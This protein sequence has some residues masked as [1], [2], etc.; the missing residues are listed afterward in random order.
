MASNQPPYNQPGQP[1]QPPY[2][3]SGQ[4]S[5]GQDMPPQ[6][7]YG[8]QYS[9]GVPPQGQ[10]GQPYAQG[11][12]PQGQYG[13][14]YGAPPQYGQMPMQGMGKDWLTV[15]LLCIF[16]GSIG[17]HRFYVGKTGTGVAMLLTFGGCGIWTIIDLIGIITGSFTDSNGQPLVKK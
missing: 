6:G 8:Q 9:Q 13:Q 11:M 3:Q 12:P 14:Q 1:G 4:P 16:V 17:V 2:G 5:Y 15:L 7:Q 10:Y